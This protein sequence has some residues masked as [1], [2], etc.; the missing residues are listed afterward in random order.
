MDRGQT[1]YRVLPAVGGSPWRHTVTDSPTTYMTAK[2]AALLA[3]ELSQCGGKHAVA[4]RVAM[5][6]RQCRRAALLIRATLR[7]VHS[8]DVWQLPPEE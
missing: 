6:E 2:E 4:A 5:I 8:S 1:A 7:Q 3:D